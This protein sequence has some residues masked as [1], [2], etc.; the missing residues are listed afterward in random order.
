MLCQWGPACSRGRKTTLSVVRT[1]GMSEDRVRELL[2]RVCFQAVDQH[3]NPRS[4]CQSL[5]LQSYSCTFN[6]KQKR[7][8]IVFLPLHMD[9][10]PQTLVTST[11]HTCYAQGRHFAAL[12]TP[13]TQG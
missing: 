9:R 5:Q 10:L 8:A 13:V 6:A 11:H 12:S 3:V 4:P 1:L 2:Q 7:L